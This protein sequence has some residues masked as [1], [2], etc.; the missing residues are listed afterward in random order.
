M[1]RSNRLTNA[2]KDS[3]KEQVTADIQRNETVAFEM[4]AANNEAD[5]TLK[6]SSND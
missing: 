5:N 2:E 4:N 3:I 1:I 6:Q